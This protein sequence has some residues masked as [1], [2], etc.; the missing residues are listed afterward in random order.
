MTRR[1]CR[2]KRAL[3]CQI[4]P[5]VLASTCKEPHKGAR[6]PSSLLLRR[7]DQALLGIEVSID[8]EGC[9]QT[10]R[11]PVVRGISSLCL[12]HQK[13]EKQRLPADARMGLSGQFVLDIFALG[14]A[15]QEQV[16]KVASLSETIDAIWSLFLG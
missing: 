2:V 1:R 6:R 4:K 10:D 11:G 13:R 7:K 14:K 15:C 5:P 3:I 16:L 9:L 8:R 12:D